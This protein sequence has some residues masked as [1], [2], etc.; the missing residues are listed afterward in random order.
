MRGCALADLDHLFARLDEG[1]ARRHGRL[2]AAGAAA[3]LDLVAVALHE[4]E[5]VEGQAELAHQHLRE[6]RRMALSEVERAGTHGHAAV[7]LENDLAEFVG[8]RRGDFQIL[9]DADAAQLSTRKALGFSRRKA[10]VVRGFQRG[11]EQRGEIAAIVDRANPCCERQFLRADVIA[12][13]QRD[14]VDAADARGLLD[15]ALH[16]VIALWPA[17]AAIGADRRRVGQNAFDVRRHD[18]RAIDALRI[19]MNVDRANQHA[20]RRHISAEIGVACHAQRQN[21]AL[22]VEG[23]FRVDIVVAAMMI[24]DETLRSHFRELDRAFQ[25]ARSVQ[26]RDIFGEDGTLHAEGAAD[27]AGQHVHLVLRYAHRSRKPVAHTEHALRLHVRG[28]AFV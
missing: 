14:R 5:F 17:R 8:R 1:G 10:F 13:A 25:I 22:G 28:E 2:G 7:F 21:I 9:P 27:L 3:D 15:H 12:L 16:D 24:A 19:A 26:Q 11:V 18:R 6:R 20:E 23:E 4:A